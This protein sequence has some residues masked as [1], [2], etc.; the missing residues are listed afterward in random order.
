MDP[1]WFSETMASTDESTR[2][3]NPEEQ[4]H[5]PHRSEKLKSHTVHLV[6]RMSERTVK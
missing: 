5:H 3:Q 2:R 1:V 4:H 6:V